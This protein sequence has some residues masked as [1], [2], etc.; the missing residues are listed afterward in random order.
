MYVFMY[1]Y[2]ADFP[3]V[4]V[5]SAYVSIYMYMCLWLIFQKVASE[6]GQKEPHSVAKSVNFKPP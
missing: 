2:L 6:T 3:K 1:V 5:L 4:F